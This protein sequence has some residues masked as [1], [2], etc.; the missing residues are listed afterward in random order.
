MTDEFDD[1]LIPP[2][3]D[4]FRDWVMRMLKE[5][6]DGFINHVIG[7]LELPRAFFQGLSDDTAAWSARQILYL[8]ADGTWKLT[9]ERAQRLRELYLDYRLRTSS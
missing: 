2:R 6:D 4:E 8:M 1:W 5:D 7:A 9:P 3:T